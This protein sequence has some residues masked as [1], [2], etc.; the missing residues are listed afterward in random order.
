[1][2]HSIGALPG[3]SSGRGDQPQPCTRDHAHGPDCQAQ[4]SRQDT[5]A[6]SK[7]G[8]TTFVYC[9]RRPFHPQA[10]RA[11]LCTHGGDVSWR[12]VGGWSG[13][14]L[15][16]PQ[17]LRATVLKWIPAAAST[18]ASSEIPRGA[19]SGTDTP[20]R[21]DQRACDGREPT[22]QRRA[23]PVQ[24]VQPGR[25]KVIRSKGFVW[26][27]S[28]HRLAY[29]WSHAGQ[30]FEVREEGDWWSEVPADEWPKGHGDREAILRGEQGP[31]RGQA[32]QSMCG[33]VALDA[34]SR[35]P[36]QTLTRGILGSVTG[37]RRSSSSGRAWT[38]RPSWQRWTRRCSRTK[39]WGSTG[40]GGGEAMGENDTEGNL[41]ELHGGRSAPGA[42]RES[43]CKVRDAEGGAPGTDRQNH[44][45]SQMVACPRNGRALSARRIGCV[46]GAGTCRPRT[47]PSRWPRRGR[48]TTRGAPRPGRGRGPRPG[49]RGTA[50]PP[51]ACA[52][53]PP[54]ADA[55]AGR[56][57]V[58]AQSRGRGG[59]RPPGIRPPQHGPLLALM[60]S[61]GVVAA[62]AHPP[63]TAPDT[64][65]TATG[66]ASVVAMTVLLHRS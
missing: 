52:P 64:R 63:A 33:S 43:G 9:R 18:S 16:C 8:I 12:V 49:V 28:S 2:H 65:C 35:P 46:R 17:R 38:R 32:V 50:A 57:T 45:S 19:P 20:L 29:Y 58:A 7:Y 47:W 21:C 59:A 14:P 4:R 3:S 60:T 13:V 22:A 30:H 34:N 1:M 42:V 62:A 15:S 36:A 25:R 48:G 24:R 66:G 31:G 39:R 5:T 11:A 37:G 10:R 53:P 6:S 23:R 61:M 55:S 51:W 27:S 41:F 40:R 26:M 44:A 56:A 54:S